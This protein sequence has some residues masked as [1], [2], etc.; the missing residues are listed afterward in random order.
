MAK[1][2]RYSQRRVGMGEAGQQW[3]K[4]RFSWE[5]KAKS[6]VKHYQEIVNF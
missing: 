6:L 2:A 5:A 4:A 1:L 3:V